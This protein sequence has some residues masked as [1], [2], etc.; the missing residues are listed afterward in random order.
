MLKLPAPGELLSSVQPA[1]LAPRLAFCGV[2]G[3]VSKFCKY[4][5]PGVE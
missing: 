5:D 1:G 2:F 3:S 4:V